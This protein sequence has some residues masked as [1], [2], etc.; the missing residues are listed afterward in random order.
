MAVK[1]KKKNY[2]LK[3]QRKKA[4]KLILLR[5]K[6]PYSKLKMVQRINT[7]SSLKNGSCPLEMLKIDTIWL[8]LTNLMK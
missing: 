5:T 8:P 1:L 4:R 3:L 2:L 6:P 7:I